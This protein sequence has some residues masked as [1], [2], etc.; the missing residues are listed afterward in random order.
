MSGDNAT[1]I[2]AGCRVCE[3]DNCP[4]R[5]FP[6]LAARSISTSTAARYPP[7]W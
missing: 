3:R 7:I 2:G 4:Q 5:A 6:A 1:P